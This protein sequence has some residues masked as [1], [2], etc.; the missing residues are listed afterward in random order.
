[1]FSIQF[2]YGTLWYGDVLRYREHVGNTAEENC[3]AFCLFQTCQ[4]LWAK[5]SLCI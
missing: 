4:L 2:S 5:A 3:S 1:M